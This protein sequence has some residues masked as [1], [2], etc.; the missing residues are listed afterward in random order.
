MAIMEKLI[1]YFDEE[2]ATAVG[3]VRDEAIAF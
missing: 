2:V 3:A 1:K